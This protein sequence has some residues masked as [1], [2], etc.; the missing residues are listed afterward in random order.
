MQT[1]LA[2][3]DFA[4]EVVRVSIA[5]LRIH[6][7]TGQELRMAFLELVPEKTVRKPDRLRLNAIRDQCLQHDR[8]MVIE[9]AHLVACRD[10]ALAC[11]LLADAAIRRSVERAKLV[12]PCV[13]GK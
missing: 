8:A 1:P 9:D 7:R 2:L 4:E 3:L 12:Q 13:V 11:G 5:R 6:G 10:A